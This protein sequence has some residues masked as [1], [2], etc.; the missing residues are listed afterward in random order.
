MSSKVICRSYGIKRLSCMSLRRVGRNTSLYSAVLLGK[1]LLCVLRR[2][3]GW[4]VFFAKCLR[5]NNF[6]DRLHEWFAGLSLFSLHS[7]LV[8]MHFA[9][10]SRRRDFF[11]AFYAYG[12]LRVSRLSH[13]EKLKYSATIYDYRVCASL[14]SALH[15]YMCISI[16]FLRSFFT[17]TRGHAVIFS[18]LLST[19]PVHR[20]RGTNYV[21]IL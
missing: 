21:A 13:S 4:S 6:H 3:V 12:N 17:Y 9:F 10:R 20:E 1:I 14:Y 2:T 15:A 8:F 16:F 5:P 18:A 19:G 7:F 11:R